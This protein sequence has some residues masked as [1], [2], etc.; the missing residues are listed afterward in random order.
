MFPTR[1]KKSSMPRS[2]TPSSF[3]RFVNNFALEKFN[4]TFSKR[5]VLPY[6]PVSLSNF[7]EYNIENLFVKLGWKEF[8]EINEKIYPNLVRSFYAN[9]T[10][11]EDRVIRSR[12]DGIDVTLSADDIAHILAFSSEGVDNFSDYLNSFDFYPEGET[13]EI[14]SRL[15]HNYNN[16]CL[17]LNDKVLL[18][19]I[20]SQISAK[21]IMLNILLPKLG[22]YGKA[23]GCITLLIYCILRGF[24][25]NLPKLMFDNM[26]IDNFEHRNLPY[27]MVLTIFFD[28]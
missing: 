9:L 15:L 21:I 11:N 17:T 3:Q 19:M 28:F 23:R 8:L 10:L 6:K 18:V 1:S 14:A 13:R 27:G 16:P 4:T 25:V 26:T 5:S 24:P 7:N 20:P 12:V 2:R 22:E